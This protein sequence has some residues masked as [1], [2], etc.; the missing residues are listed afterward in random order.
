MFRTERKKNK[1]KNQVFHRQFTDYVLIY[2]SIQQYNFC[3]FI[4]QMVFSISFHHHVFCF[5]WPNVQMLMLF[6][7]DSEN[8]NFFLLNLS[9]LLV[10][11]WTECFFFVLCSGYEIKKIKLMSRIVHVYENNMYKR[12]VCVCMCVLWVLFFLDPHSLLLI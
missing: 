1:N 10:E 7:V 4:Y 3:C 6:F 2:H 8:R 5:G 11:Y 12:Y 9:R